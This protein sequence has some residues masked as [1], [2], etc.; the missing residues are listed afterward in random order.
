MTPAKLRATVVTRIV[1]ALIGMT[2]GLYALIGA[3]LIVHQMQNGSLEGFVLPGE[4][5]VAAGVFGG[6]LV[7][8]LANSKGGA[9]GGTSGPVPVTTEPGDALVV[10]E[11]PEPVRL[12]GHPHT[13]D[14]A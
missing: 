11:A 6:S 5:W 10:R 9:E 2:V 3:L 12:H 13:P 8:F 1:W 7:T 4:M 14:A